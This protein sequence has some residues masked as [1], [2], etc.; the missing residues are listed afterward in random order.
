MLLDT[1]VEQSDKVPKDNHTKCKNSAFGA[2]KFFFNN[3]AVSNTNIDT[4]TIMVFNSFALI[5]EKCGE[6]R[7]YNFTIAGEE[8]TPLKIVKH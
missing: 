1:M 6:I 3:I 5:C 8:T 4:G 2:H 7:Q